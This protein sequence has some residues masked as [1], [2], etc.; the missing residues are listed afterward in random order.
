M[1]ATNKH[2]RQLSTLYTTLLTQQLHEYVLTVVHHLHMKICCGSL[3]ACWS[4]LCPLQNTNRALRGCCSG[5]NSNIIIINNNAL[6]RCPPT[7]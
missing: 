2:K 5:T 3:L 4:D 1:R 6:L 7:F